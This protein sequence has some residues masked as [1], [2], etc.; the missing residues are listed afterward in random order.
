MF[1]ENS[2]NYHAFVDGVDSTVIPKIV[3]QI[4]K[5]SATIAQSNSTSSIVYIGDGNF[6]GIELPLN[7]IGNTISFLGSN[8][9]IS[10][11]LFV[12]I[13]NSGSIYTMTVQ[14]SSFQTVNSTAFSGVSYIMLQSGTPSVPV[15]Q[16]SSN[17]NLYLSPQVYTLTNNSPL[18]VN[19]PGSELH[20]IDSIEYLS[21]INNSGITMYNIEGNQ[22][23]AKLGRPGLQLQT[24]AGDLYLDVHSGYFRISEP[25]SS[26]SPFIVAGLVTTIQD[27][28][29]DQILTTLNNTLSLCSGGQDLNIGSATVT[30][31][32]GGDKNIILDYT[33]LYATSNADGDS[34][35]ITNGG[36]S[37]NAMGGDA[38][39]NLGFDTLMVNSNGNGDSYKLFPDGIVCNNATNNRSITLSNEQLYVIDG[40]NSRSYRLNY[41]GVD[42]SDNGGDALISMSSSEI[43]IYTNG[44]DNHINLTFNS[45]DI[46][47]TTDPT[48]SMTNAD[49]G[50]KVIDISSSGIVTKDA[51]NNT[52]S[53]NS[54]GFSYE[55]SDLTSYIRL[56]SNGVDVIFEDS[57]VIISHNRLGVSSYYDSDGDDRDSTIAKQIKLTNLGL[58]LPHYT[59]TERQAFT[60][61]ETDVLIFDSTLNKICIKTVAG[62]SSINTTAL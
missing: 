9:N 48:I 43:N 49:T 58:R 19:I 44:G 46:A 59:T 61:A 34:F 36:L 2:S 1:P 60:S 25:A 10:E 52:I 53:A 33:Q 22:T 7:F 14:S 13:W 11:S 37:T 56:N 39:L 62:W 17:Y 4:N 27:Q 38:N 20:L 32:D 16:S 18:T 42:I 3:D 45:I 57:R 15:I 54:N 24:D 5:K 28:E 41:D 29:D 50:V 51:N 30:M 26:I 47:G 21:I 40:D 8:Q 55:M 6:L 23:A 12:P 31:S 35:K